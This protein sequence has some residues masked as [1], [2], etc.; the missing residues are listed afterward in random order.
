MSPKIIMKLPFK[1]TEN[2]LFVMICFIFFGCM[3]VCF[4]CLKYHQI[5]IENYQN[6]K[7]LVFLWKFLCRNL[8]NRDRCYYV[9]K[10]FDENIVQKYRQFSICNDLFH[11][12]WIDG[13]EKNH[14]G[15][16]FL[17][18]EISSNLNWYLSKSRI[19]CFFV[20]ILYPNLKNRNRC[21]YVSK[22]FYENIVQK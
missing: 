10:K 8:E 12:F 5:S 9:P 18:F 11:I 21:E 13:L 7:F 17:L 1:S 20:R 22:K 15:S 14:C 19:S 6:H 2:F 4:F 3:E 16:M